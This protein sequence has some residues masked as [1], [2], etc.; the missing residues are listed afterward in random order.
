MTFEKNFKRKLIFSVLFFFTIFSS[1]NLFSLEHFH[2][3]TKIEFG[4]MKGE[5]NEYVFTTPMTGNPTDY[6]LSRLD[7]D[8]NFI[9]FIGCSFDATII[10][11]VFV[12]L[13][14]RIG[15]ASKSGNMQ[16]YD[17]LNVGAKGFDKNWYDNHNWLTNYSKHDNYLTNY[18]DG[19]VQLGGIIN[20][21]CEFFLLPS[22]SIKG[23]EFSFDGKN[24]FSQY[25]G[26]TPE[27]YNPDGSIKEW[28]SDITKSE[29]SG[30]VISYNQQRMF[31]F[32]GVK[33][34]TTV[35]PKFYFSLEGKFSPLTMIGAVDT[36]WQRLTPT[37]FLDQPIGFGTWEI[38]G[39]V[40]FMPNKNFKLSLDVD[41]QYVPVMKGK[42]YQKYASEKYFPSTPEKDILGGAGSKLFSISLGGVMAF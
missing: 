31:L 40:K 10:E 39:S 15:F 20:L 37:N 33:A 1:T 41:F 36:H 42:N 38:S 21:P 4:V 7:W 5:I 29:M 34:Y 35:V 13:S 24:G 12:G 2:L 3:D 28:T 14:G 6:M 17:W 27:P 23:Q 22:F 11:H 19:E 32:V 26:N 8:V 9:R 16:D 30:K 18:L 25:V